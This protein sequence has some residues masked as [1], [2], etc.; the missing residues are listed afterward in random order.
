MI[1][2]LTLGLIAAD[3]KR[4]KTVNIALFSFILI[5]ALL[6][7]TGVLTI[8]RLSGAL[9]QIFD[10]AKP[11]H[12]LQMHVGD[13]DQTIIAQ[14]AEQTGMVQSH[15]I[16]DMVNIEGVNIK[17]AKTDGTT[18]SL[19]DSLLDNYFVDQNANFDYLLDMNNQIVSVTDGQVGV[20][21]GYAKDY[22]IEVGDQLVVNVE[23]EAITLDVAYIV[24]DAQMGS[25][26]ASSIRFLVS[27]DDFDW[28]SQRALRHESI[29]GFRLNSEDE[30]D[31]FSA[32]Y[33]SE[34]SDMPKNGI[35]ITLPLIKIVDSIGDGLMSAMIVLVGLILIAIAI[36]N[37]KF[38]IQSTVEDE[39]R[40]IGVLKAI[41]L[42]KRS[43]NQLY[44]GKY[45]LFT[46]VACLIAAL[47]SFGLVNLFLQNISLN[48]G[49]SKLTMYSY[50]LPFVAVFILYLIVMFSVNRILKIISKMS[51]LD[52]LVEGEIST[53][54]EQASK[55]SFAKLKNY[56]NNADLSLALHDYKVNFKAWLIYIIVFFLSTFS[57]LMPFNMYM[58]MTSPDF[59]NYVGAAKSDVRIAVEYD[60]SLDDTIAQIENQ[61][62]A[63]NEVEAWHKYRSL[64]GKIN[65]ETGKMSFLVEAGDY[66]SFAIKMEKGQLP[67]S[68]DEIALSALN[69]ER[70]ELEMGSSL[71]I[72]L[73]GSEQQF[74][75]VG[76]YQDIT[77]GGITAKV[78]D[79]HQGDI[80]Q[81]AF[82]INLADDVDIEQFV[83]RWSQQYTDAKIVAVDKLLNQT[84][85]SITSSLLFAVI[86][87]FLMAVVIIALITLL[88]M[89]LRLRRNYAEDATLLAL[90]YRRFSVRLM[91]LFKSALSIVIGIGLGVIA[92]LF[93]GE[94]IIS[95]VLA[96]MQFG[97]TRMDFL[98]QPLPFA[99]FGIVIPL[100]VGLI[101]TWLASEKINRTSVMDRE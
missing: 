58:T 87:V 63:D 7:A 20:P 50:I 64:R 26:L 12:F 49:L 56:L 54:K 15:E 48:F 32:Q 89:A 44:K 94:T 73:D 43:I 93:F 52:A 18:S 29:I 5:S 17:I 95:I 37:M 71:T 99:L 25:S 57:I 100:A 19:S 3:I 66:T 13:Y 36:L 2:N 60:S 69:A 23:G 82:F 41:G 96:V 85:G 91:Y 59:I 97:L 21:V 42:N 101:V 53:K 79:D 14:F 77:N 61:L 75:V 35:A 67:S 9:D 92:S 40:E 62:A 6:M 16:Q 46:I 11:P 10:V 78:S 47:L 55:R 81:Y 33:N 31:A 72:E 28:I 38:T 34:S 65:S 24:R 80:V 4:N 86:A 30:I 90:G 68:R 83:K 8:E 1:D 27:E 70:L 45:R 74:N 51:V 39:V 22:G 98:I 88:F 76:I 84:L